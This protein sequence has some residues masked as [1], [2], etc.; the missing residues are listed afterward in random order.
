M[1]QFLDVF[2]P[3]LRDIDTVTTA[4]TRHLLSEQVG[5]T[6]RDQLLAAEARRRGMD[7][8]PAVAHE[9]LKWLEK[10]VY[11]EV[12]DE[13][14]AMAPAAAAAG[15][16]RAILQRRADSLKAAY[17]VSIRYEILDTLT[18]SDSPASRQMGLQ[19]F[20]LGSKRLAVPVTD[21]IWG[22]GL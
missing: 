9:R 22:A 3:S 14:A 19:L 18:V 6:M 8:A 2:W 7:R 13:A 4:R 20:K 15:A 11:E 12:R 16:V 10:T 5:L 1:R 21:G 17:P